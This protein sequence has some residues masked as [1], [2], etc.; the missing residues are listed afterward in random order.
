MSVDKTLEERAKNLFLHLVDMGKEAP[1]DAF[2]IKG[3]EH[4]RTMIAFIVM[5]FQEVQAEE[6]SRCAKI[7]DGIVEEIAKR[8][9]HSAMVA[10]MCA[11]KIR[12]GGEK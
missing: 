9:P 4:L 3:Q 8:D 11:A 7:C 2:G 6:R 12:G 10:G 1:S 5:A